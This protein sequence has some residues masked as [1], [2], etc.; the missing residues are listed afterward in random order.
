M[1]RRYAFRAVLTGWSLLVCTGVLLL[2]HYSNN[3]GKA[4]AAPDV[5]PGSVEMALSEEK[6]TLLV[7]L[8]PQCS[9]SRSTLRE[10]ERLM[11]V[12][13]DEV[14][15]R[16]VFF[17]AS[18]MDSDWVEGDLWEIARAIPHVTSFRDTDG[19]L[20]KQFGAFTSGQT[21]LYDTTGKLLFKGGITPSRGH[22]G[23]NKGKQYLLAI[24]RNQVIE[25][26][27]SLV[28]GC[29]ILGEIQ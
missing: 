3:P 13:G 23:D 25:T 8:H 16:A 7:L 11:A 2:G 17:D 12:V 15:T 14:D 19:Q 1:N 21:L 29:S 20:I 9:C 26:N 6:P 22:E 24:L 28:F 27:E 18:S 4:A 5:W 10:L